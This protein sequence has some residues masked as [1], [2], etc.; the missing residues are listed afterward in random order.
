M[1]PLVGTVARGGDAANG[2]ND[3]GGTRSFLLGGATDIFSAFG[4]KIK[5]G[6]EGKLVL[7]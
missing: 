7:T 3:S 2:F 6:G 1:P 4:K 5:G